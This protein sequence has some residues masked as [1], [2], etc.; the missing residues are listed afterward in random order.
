MIPQPFTCN[1]H[2]VLLWRP[3][4]SSLLPLPHD[5]KA[6]V[7]PWQVYLVSGFIA[8]K[9]LW[10]DLHAMPIHPFV[11]RFMMMKMMRFMS[12]FLQRISN[13]LISADIVCQMPILCTLAHAVWFVIQQRAWVRSAPTWDFANP[14]YI[15][16]MHGSCIGP[17]GKSNSNCSIC[18]W[19]IVMFPVKGN[20]GH[21][22]SV[23]RGTQLGVSVNST[24]SVHLH[25]FWL[26]A[27]DSPYVGNILFLLIKL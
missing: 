18:R 7:L 5:P 20:Q 9:K 10:P 13:E 15:H 26:L 8:V 22:A 24:E 11:E 25:F 2:H 21:K 17:A 4:P 27:D 16:K 1:V 6:P 12:H 19:L 14:Q 3:E 23:S